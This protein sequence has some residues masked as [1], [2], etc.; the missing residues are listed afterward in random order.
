MADKSTERGESDRMRSL[1]KRYRER[2][3][4][5]KAVDPT[6]QDKKEKE[7]EKEKTPGSGGGVASQQFLLE[8]RSYYLCNGIQ[9][10]QVYAPHS[11]SLV[12]QIVL[13]DQPMQPNDIVI[14]HV[15]RLAS[16]HL[17]QLIQH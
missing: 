5:K 12:G 16:S 4:T 15:K 9:K 1:E 17:Q 13:N 2:A 3:D 8:E 14:Y 7:K 10:Q 6:K 11:T